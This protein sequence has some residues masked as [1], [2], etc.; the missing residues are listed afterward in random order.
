[1]REQVEK[2]VA[3]LQEEGELTQLKLSRITPAQ[4]EKPVY[5]EGQLWTAR[6]VLAHLVAA[7]RGHQRL[8]GNVAQGGPGAPADLDIDR[9]NRGTVAQLAG[10]TVEELL[11]DAA[12]VR[13]ETVALVSALDD[14]DLD[15]RGRHPVLGEDA[16][17]VDMIRIIVMHVKMHLRD[18]QRVL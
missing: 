13:R 8:I 3:K 16:A 17:L 4:W 12:E 18:L 9:Y 5:S 15:R 2:L 7:E 11:L 10:C 14:A 6:D 1:M